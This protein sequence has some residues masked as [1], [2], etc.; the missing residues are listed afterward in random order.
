MPSADDDI[1]E[2]F[3]NADVIEFYANTGVLPTYLQHRQLRRA[4]MRCVG[5][6]ALSVV[7]Q[8]TID[9]ECMPRKL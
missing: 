7:G 2:A 8:E 1:E 4:L 6:T 9:V 3:A 5:Q